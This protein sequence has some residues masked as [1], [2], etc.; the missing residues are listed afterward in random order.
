VYPNGMRKHA[1]LVAIALGT[2]LSAGSLRADP[3]PTWGVSPAPADDSP[4]G[5]AR[6]LLNRARA[7]DDAATSDERYAVDVA[8]RL[9]ALRIAAKVARDRADRATGDDKEALVAKA[10][11]LETDVV[12]SEAETVS[13]KKIAA[14]HRRAAKDLRA[15]ALRLVKDGNAATSTSAADH[16]L[17]CDPPYRFTSDGRK[18]YRIECLK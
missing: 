10:E 18:I 9:P 14:D 15:R 4:T 1:L 8:A 16:D 7:L 3:L 11:D 2:L 5:R 12:I 6:D 13:K 17:A